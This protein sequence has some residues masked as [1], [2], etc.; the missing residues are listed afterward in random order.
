MLA[1]RTA[2]EVFAANHNVTGLYAGH[3]GLVNVLHAVGGQLGGALRVQ[4]TGGN[5]HIGV[6]VITVLKNRSFCVHASTS[7]GSVMWPVSALAAA[8]AGLAR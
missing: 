1:G 7:L 5:D 8:V 4:V 6:N 3:K 2:A